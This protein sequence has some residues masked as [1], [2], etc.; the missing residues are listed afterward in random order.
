MSTLEPGILKVLRKANEKDPQGDMSVLQIAEK[1]DARAGWV[2]RALHVLAK[3]GKVIR[4][5]DTDDDG[6]GPFYRLLTLD[7]IPEASAEK[8]EEIEEEETPTVR[9]GKTETTM[10][11]D[12]GLVVAQPKSALDPSPGPFLRP[13]AFLGRVEDL[14]NRAGFITSYV[15]FEQDVITLKLAKATGKA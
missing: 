13:M 12:V 5:R 14:A 3:E 7:N 1:I 2:D 8:V 15:E 11:F 6:R 4:T 9:V 10:T